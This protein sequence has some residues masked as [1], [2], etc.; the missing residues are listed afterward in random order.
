M[1]DLT[2]DAGDSCGEFQGTG[3][4]N[5][6][7]GLS[8]SIEETAICRLRS[9]DEKILEP[10]RC[11]APRYCPFAFQPIRL[12]CSP[13]GEDGWNSAE[14]YLEVEAER[15]VLYV[16]NVQHDHFIERKIAASANLPE[17]GKAWRDA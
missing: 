16:I 3:E 10:S 1:R 2:Y 13:S 8:L 5:G 17:T 4:V 12:V 14:E 9:S 7:L 11:W 6:R 15:P